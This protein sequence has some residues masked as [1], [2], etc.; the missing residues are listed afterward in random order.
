MSED[1]KGTS[2]V[3]CKYNLLSK[4]VLV[5]MSEHN[6]SILR[7]TIWG[8]KIVARLLLAF[9]GNTVL[10]TVGGSIIIVNKV[11]KGDNLDTVLPVA[12]SLYEALI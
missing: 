2:L 5:N 9:E 3:E 7:W 4:S 1:Q 8:A 11:G 10:M 12:K 6:N